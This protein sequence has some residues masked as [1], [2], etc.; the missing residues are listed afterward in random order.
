MAANEDRMKK[1]EFLI[2]DWNLEYKVPKSAFA[3]AETGTGKGTFRRALKD[4]YV[5]FDSVLSSYKLNKSNWL[6][7]SAS[8]S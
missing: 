4:R 1:F 2:G 5:Y 8:D 7:S 3:E 6:R